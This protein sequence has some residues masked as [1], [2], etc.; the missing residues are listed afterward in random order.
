MDISS[1]FSGP[2]S[3]NASTQSDTTGATDSGAFDQL[4]AQAMSAS[5]SDNTAQ[6]TQ[7]VGSLA[8]NALGASV[9]DS[10]GS[11]LPAATTETAAGT[12]TDSD[13]AD[14]DV[15]TGTVT[16]KSD[17]GLFEDGDSLSAGDL[18]DIVNPLQHIP[19]VGTYYR[20]LTGDEIG[21]ASQVAGC[22][23]YGG[24]L[25]A[26][27]ALGS[28]GFEAATGEEQVEY[29]TD[30]VTGGSSDRTARG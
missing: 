15:S 12:T 19:I 11:V 6:T 4:F 25:G 10:L 18:V 22:T 21:Y 8:A 1:I 28:I 7:T 2:T 5:G 20:E 29:A 16:S 24:A 17:R 30:M 14:A 27:S 23:L 13:S 3:S 9:A 26:L